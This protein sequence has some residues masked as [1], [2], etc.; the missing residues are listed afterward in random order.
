MLDFFIDVQIVL[1]YLQLS[2]QQTPPLNSDVGAGADAED[3]TGS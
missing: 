1:D 2:V 3:S